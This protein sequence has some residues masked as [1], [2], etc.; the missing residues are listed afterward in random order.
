LAIDYRRA[1]GRFDP[2]PALAAD[3]VGSAI[4]K[5]WLLRTARGHSK[6]TVAIAKLRTIMQPDAD[7]LAGPQ[8]A[9]PE[10]YSARVC[11]GQEL[12]SLGWPISVVIVKVAA[13]ISRV[14]FA[15]GQPVAA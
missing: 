4:G 7:D 10:A 6:R 12:Q 15:P 9:H 1:G 13:C 8:P 5:V 14:P 2:L 3:L 11:S